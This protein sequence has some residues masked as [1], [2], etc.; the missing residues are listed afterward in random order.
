MDNGQIVY[1]SKILNIPSIPIYSNQP[2]NPSQLEYPAQEASLLS[3]SLT[4]RKSTTISS[5]GSRDL[6][7]SPCDN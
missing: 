7:N 3:V 6:N 5:N 1:K 2:R 4:C